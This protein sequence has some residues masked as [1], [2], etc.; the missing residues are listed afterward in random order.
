MQQQRKRPFKET[1][2]YYSGIGGVILG[3][4]YAV[5]VVV[6]SFVHSADNNNDEKAKREI[7]RVEACGEI[8][9]ETIR[10]F[11]INGVDN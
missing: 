4:V 10:A 9:D 1:G 6:T 11:C 5:V 2:W 7:A 8:E 3:S